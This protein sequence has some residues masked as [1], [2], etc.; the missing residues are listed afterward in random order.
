M[1]KR[2]YEEDS[3]NLR[4]SGRYIAKLYGPDGKLKQEVIG[5]NVICTNGKEFLASFLY[6]AAVAAATNT[7]KYLAIGSDATAESAAN[8]TLGIE[9]ARHTGTV[10]YVSNQIYQVTATFATGLGTGSIYEY[11][12]LSSSTGGTLIS[13]DTEPLITKGA[14][15]KLIV[16]YQ[17]TLS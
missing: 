1:V 8:T 7:C 11:G 17:M 12:L 9:L 16:T 6:S 10:S 14:N 2:V 13:R 3:K 15:D 4:L 5:K